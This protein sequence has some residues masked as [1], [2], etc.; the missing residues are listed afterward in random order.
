MKSIFEHN[1]GSHICY[2]IDVPGRLAIVKNCDEIEGLKAALETIGLQKTV[3]KAINSRI[4]K[5]EK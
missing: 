4:R 1:Y 5:L 3:E 2:S